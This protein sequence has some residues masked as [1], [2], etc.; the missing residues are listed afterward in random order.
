[1][2]TSYSSFE[3]D[4]SLCTACEIGRAYRKVVLSDGCK[5]NPLVLVLGEA[6]GADEIVEGKPFVGKAGKLL[7]QVLN[8]NGFSKRNTL[9]S[10][11]IPCRPQDNVFPQDSSLVTK[12]YDKWLRQEILLTKPRYVI[13][14]GAQPLKYVLGL[15]GITKLRG[16]Y[17]DLPL[18]QGF[19]KCMPTF[20]PS[21]V[22][23]KQYME[24]GKQIR[25]QFENDIR[26]V[27]KLA[28]FIV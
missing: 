9:I 7:R 16:D 12:C 25:H 27:A 22:L 21:Y 19:L 2:Y 17:Y 10:N 5:T 24:E 15:T 23:R 1:M 8:D 13:L 18:P 11:I 26:G 14:L 3:M 20:H 6:P 28:Q 4:K